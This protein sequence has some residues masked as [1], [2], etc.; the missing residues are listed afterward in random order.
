M[1]KE[2]EHKLLKRFKWLYRQYYLDKRHTCMC[3]GFSCGDGWFDILWMLSLAIEDEVNPNWFQKNYPELYDV[4]CNKLC[5][6]KLGAKFVN[7]FMPYLPSAGQVKE[8]FGTLRFY[9]DGGSDRIE[10]LIVIA[11]RATAQTCEQCGDNGHLFTKGWCY[12][13][14]KKHMKGTDEEKEYFKN[15]Y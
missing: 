2:L 4:L 15:W 10:D 6:F 11:E 1:K 12:V 3:W 5:K 7:K 9:I 13:T 14:C 8:K